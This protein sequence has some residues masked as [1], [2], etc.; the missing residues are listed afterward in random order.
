MLR[1][2]CKH[3]K[4]EQVSLH[5]R[6]PAELRLQI[7]FPRP[8]SR[9]FGAKP[10]SHSNPHS[11][12]N[13]RLG[14]CDRGGDATRSRDALLQVAK[15]GELLEARQSQVSC[16]VLLSAL[17]FAREL[18]KSPAQRP[19]GQ[20]SLMAGHACQLMDRPQVQSFQSF[21]LAS[22]GSRRQALPTSTWAASWNSSPTP[23]G[24]QA[25]PARFC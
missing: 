9:R 6:C 17:C 3:C 25:D 13:M 8:P 19:L 23:D 15:S 1:A 18:P 10:N 20:G 4:D 5:L 16:Q 21:S 24:P 12:K 14:G 22:P 7:S 11:G 2:F